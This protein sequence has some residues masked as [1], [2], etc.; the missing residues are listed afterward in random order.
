MWPESNERYKNIGEFII[1][2][3]YKIL[4]Q[5]KNKNKNNH[6]TKYRILKSYVVTWKRSKQ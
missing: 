2:Y 3:C 1:W 6:V 4:N 5:L